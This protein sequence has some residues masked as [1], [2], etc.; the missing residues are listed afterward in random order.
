M[1]IGV[2]GC[3]AMGSVYSGY[4]SQVH[5]VYVCDTWKEH[6]DA[7][8]EHG[9]KVDEA[10][11]GEEPVTKVFRPTY[12]TTD[13]NEI[14]PVDLLIVFVRYMF[15]EAAIRNAHSMVGPN[16][17]VMTLQ[18]GMGNYD[19]IA[20]VIPEERICIGTTPHGSTFVDLGHVKHTGH[21]PMNIGTLKGSKEIAYKAAEAIRAAGFE[22]EVLDN[23]LEVVW[24]KLFVNIAVN[25]TTALLD[26]QNHFISENTYARK[27]SELMV[28]EA[29]EVANASGC[30]FDPDAEL[31]H[32][33]DMATATG[34]N[35]SSMLQDVSREKETEIEI[36]NG[37]VGRI[38]RQYGIKTPY[39]DFMTLMLKAKQ[40]IYLGK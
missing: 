17:I 30:H 27:L 18:N 10:V 13:P 11:P 15:L 3:G 24:H 34:G 26:Q 33:F 6:V 2:L 7:I 38:G 1:R 16:T 14:Q 22:I 4:L 40:S 39:N 25:A 36:I 21:G 35:R 20:K 32:A 31:E 19:E 9:I 28:Y 29:V 12:I 5:D 23:P 37:A 8:K